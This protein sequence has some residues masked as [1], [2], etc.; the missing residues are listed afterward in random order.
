ME[1]INIF[2]VYCTDSIEKFRWDINHLNE[3]ESYE[4]LSK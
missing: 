4:Y 1:K 3:Y 2:T